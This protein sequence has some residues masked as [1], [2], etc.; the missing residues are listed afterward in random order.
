MTAAKTR[1]ELWHLGDLVGTGEDSPNGLLL[2]KAEGVEY[3]QDWAKVSPFVGQMSI[4]RVWSGPRTYQQELWTW[5]GKKV[6]NILNS[7]NE[8]FWK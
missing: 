1:L 5:D 8:R 3:Q 2:L 7:V 4:E 6:W